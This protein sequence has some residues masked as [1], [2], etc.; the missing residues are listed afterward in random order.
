MARKPRIEYPGALFHIIVRGNNRQNIFHD[1]EDRQNYLKHLT[2]YLTEG[3]I[4]LYCFCLMMNHIHLLLEMGEC[5]LSRVLQRLHTWYARYYNQKYKRLGHLFQGRYKA[6]LCDKDAYLLELVRYIH[7]NPV[8]ACMTTNPREYP[9]SSHRAYLGE[10]KCEW[11]DIGLVLSQ[12]ANNITHARMLYEEFVMSKLDEGRREDLYRLTDQ[13]ILGEEAFVAKV[14]DINKTEITQPILRGLCF[15]LPTLQT[16]IERELNMDG[17][18]MLK[19]KRSGV[20]ARRIFC[21]VA[22]QFGG[23]KSKEVATYLGKDMATVTQGV[24]YISQALGEK[25]CIQNKVNTIVSKIERGQTT[26]QDQRP[27]ATFGRIA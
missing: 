26:F 12:F 5:S 24:R 23:F 20:L 2:F 14:M 27:M 6:V 8:R 15:D 1:D 25:N 13:R 21:Y 19:L 9:W 10:E 3:K 11:L 17:D 22:R 16:L 18:T 4:T 7:L